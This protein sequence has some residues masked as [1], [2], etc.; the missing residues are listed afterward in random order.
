MPVSRRRYAC[1]RGGGFKVRRREEAAE[2][3]A[4]ATMNFLLPSEWEGVKRGENEA[5]EAWSDWEVCKERMQVPML[6]V[7]L[8]QMTST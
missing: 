3:A 5:Q 1:V 8:R 2:T 6:E 7:K 4:E